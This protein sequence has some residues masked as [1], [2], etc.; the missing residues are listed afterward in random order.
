MSSFFI[1]LTIYFANLEN[2]GKLKEHRKIFSRYIEIIQERVLEER[3]QDSFL[4][5][6][7]CMAQII[8]I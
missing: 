2:E 1:N 6:L 3:Y 5:Y 8:I 4:K 7:M